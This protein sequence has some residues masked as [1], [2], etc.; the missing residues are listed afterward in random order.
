MLEKYHLSPDQAVYIGDSLGDAKSA[1]GAGL[2]FIASL[3]SGLRTEEDFSSIP[4]DH[5][6][7]K[8]P[9]IVKIIR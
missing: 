3:E 9:E 1:K 2:H 5:F 4:V 8:F 7:K 6:I